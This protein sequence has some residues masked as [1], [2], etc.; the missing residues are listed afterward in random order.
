MPHRKI[1]DARTF[2]EIIHSRPEDL[3]RQPCTV[4]ADAALGDLLPG[5]VMGKITTGGKV[6]RV[7]RTVVKTGGAFSTAAAT[8][9]VVDADDIFKVGDVLK[10]AAGA[11]VGTIQSIA[12]DVITLT[13]NAAVNVAQGAE[14]MASDGAEKAAGIL[15]HDVDATEVDRFS[16]LVTR[17][18]L[19]ESKLIG[20]TAQAKTELGAVSLPNDLLKL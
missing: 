5:T 15:F 19:V 6:R 2:V 8:G 12:G 10:N 9:S 3:N 17:G 1:E 4:V 14:I 20:L 13:A 18:N 16:A 11:A 7:T